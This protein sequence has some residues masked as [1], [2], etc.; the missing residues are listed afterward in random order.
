MAFNLAWDKEGE[1]LYETGVDRG[2]LYVYDTANHKYGNGVAWN[3]LTSIN[4][5][6]SG[7]DPTDLWADN[8]KYISIRAAEEYGFTINAYMSPDEFDQCD[9]MA[10]PI[11][12]VRISGQN[13]K[14]FGFSYRS[15]IGNDTDLNDHGYE[16][17]LIY[18]ATCSP[19]DKDRSTVN[20][21]PDAIE[22]SWECTTVPVP[23]G[24]NFKATAHIVVK[25][26]DFDMNDSTEK[27]LW[28][29]FEE[30]VYGKI[31][32]GSTYTAVTFTGSGT[33]G[34]PYVPAYTPSKYYTRSGSEGDY[35]YTLLTTTTEPT[36]WGTAD[37]FYTKD[38]LQATLPS[39]A[40]VIEYFGG[41]IDA[42]G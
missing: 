9:G 18:G 36:G 13:R 5:S 2:V 31:G 26:T 15:L 7:A 12:G 27:A 11:K 28:D 41:D 10:T 42:Q 1:K 25:S 23:V 20:D 21:S 4:D 19:S 22:F 34:S 32:G 6:P 24:G 30:L 14:M 3:G 29:G 33:S 40:E 38:D 16:I 39:P 8:I 35:T 37:T 17:H